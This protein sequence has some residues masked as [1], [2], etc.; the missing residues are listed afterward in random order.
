MD[1]ETTLKTTLSGPC[2]CGDLLESR[3]SGIKRFVPTDTLPARIGIAFRSRAL[4]GVEQ[5]VGMVDELRR[6]PPFGAE[7][8]AGGMRRDPVRGQRN[9]RPQS[10][11]RLRSARRTAR[12]SREFAEPLE[13]WLTSID[14]PLMNPL[15]CTR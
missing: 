4:E 5:P 8:F 6:G 9:G 10:R 3:G 2:C 11:R 7:C 12:S 1:G 14:L 13:C 15:A